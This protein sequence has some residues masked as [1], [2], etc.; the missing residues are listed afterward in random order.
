MRSIQFGLGCT[1]AAALLA[2]APA[3][4]DPSEEGDQVETV[5]NPDLLSPAEWDEYVAD[6]QYLYGLTKPDVAVQINFADPRQYNVVM[7]RLKLTGKTVD[8][9]PYLFELIET[10]RAVHKQRGYKAGSFANDRGFSS[11]NESTAN[12]RDQHYVETGKLLKI[13]SLQAEV[14]GT[15]S[16]AYVGGRAFSR[17]DISGTTSGGLPVAPLVAK[18]E[19]TN[20]NGNV[21]ANLT[22]STT[23]K[24]S[25]S[26]AKRYALGSLT[27]VQKAD[28]SFE[29]TFIRN[30]FGSTNAALTASV[31]TL[32][33]LVVTAPLPN[34]LP[35][36]NLI[37]VCIGRTWTSDCDYVLDQTMSW[38]E[39]KMPLAGSRTITSAHEFDADWLASIQWA[40]N[41][42]PPQDPGVDTGSLK[43]VLT[44]FGGGCDV[45]DRDTL[46][47][48]MAQFW[49]RVT[50]SADKKTLSWDLTKGPTGD[51]SAFFDDQC[52][53]IQN[54]AKLTARI[55]LRMV[56]VP[57]AALKSFDTSVTITSDPTVLRPDKLLDQITLTNS[58]LAEGTQIELGNGKLAAVETLKVGQEVHNP[59][60][61]TDHALVITDTAKGVERT[62]MVRIRDERGRTLLLT[63]M[64]PLATADRGMVQARYI[65][66]GDVVLTKDGQSKL[67]DVTR[68]PYMGKVYNLKVGTEA[69]MA[70]LGK[71]QTVVYANGFV[72]GDGQIQTK[73]ESLS[74]MGTAPLTEQWRRD[75]EMSPNRD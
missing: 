9:S 60:D 45:T 51:H 56:T 16:S 74:M 31:P 21:G 46:Y 24:V 68:E 18:E 58:C 40:L 2:C 73:Y 4:P 72:V 12:L 41:Q 59:Y 11:L 35:P 20:Q 62:P 54:V 63:E 69:E 53:Q 37:S 19:Y 75:F 36:N 71:D 29:S 57:P 61:R 70:S 8:N 43:L 17:I 26:G 52:A 30:E 55:P 34:I 33:D 27:T 13:S 50:L 38:W 14:A 10:Q 67:V 6:Q 7:S 64:H 15:A 28:G 32:T 42:V 49:N 44:N 48:K 39:I 25:L 23:G 47:A 66:P 3:A 5:A 65:Q 22:V 1:Y